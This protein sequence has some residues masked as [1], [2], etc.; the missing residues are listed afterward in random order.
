MKFSVYIC[1]LSVGLQAMAKNTR[2]KKLPKDKL[3]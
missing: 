1:I 2:A 3:I